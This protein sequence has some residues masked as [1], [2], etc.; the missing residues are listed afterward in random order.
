MKRVHG[1]AIN[2]IF[3]L[4]YLTLLSYFLI[5][6]MYEKADGFVIYMYIAHRKTPLQINSALRTVQFLMLS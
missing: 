1:V 5:Y 6:F 2:D 4:L 3:T